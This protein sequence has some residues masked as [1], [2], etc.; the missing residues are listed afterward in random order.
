MDDT[1]IIHC[2]KPSD[3]ANTLGSVSSDI[4]CVKH[5]CKDENLVL[6]GK[7]S[8]FMIFAPK[9]IFSEYNTKY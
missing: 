4:E 5:S 7:K 2:C 8:N 6:N 1:Q 9:H 3:I